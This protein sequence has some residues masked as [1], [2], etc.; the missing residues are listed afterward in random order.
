MEKHPED[1]GVVEPASASLAARVFP[2]EAGRVDHRTVDYGTRHVAY[3]IRTRLEFVQIFFLSCSGLMYVYLW[4]N[5]G[6]HNDYF[7]YVV[8]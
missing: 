5:D 4:R 2:D 6:E 1:V 3:K 7:E 8:R